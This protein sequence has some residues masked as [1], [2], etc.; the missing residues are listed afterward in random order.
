MIRSWNLSLKIWSFDWSSEKKCR[1]LVTEPPFSARNIEFR[2]KKEFFLRLA[3]PYS[4]LVQICIIIYA[5]FPL[6]GVSSMNSFLRCWAAIHPLEASTPQTSPP[7]R[8]IASYRWHEQVVSQKEV[9]S[10]KI[11]TLR[12]IKSLNLF[13]AKH[14]DGSHCRKEKRYRKD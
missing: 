1:A 11:P 13:R 7:A 14:V 3:V 12:R 5:V 10:M 9:S 2:E 4:E 8:H 6:R